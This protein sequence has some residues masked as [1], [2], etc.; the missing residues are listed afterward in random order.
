[1]NVTD[2]SDLKAQAQRRLPA[3]VYTYLEGGGYEEETLRRNRE[4]LRRF[5]LVPRVLH[6]VT[7]RNM[8]V[9]I[10]GQKLA[11]PLVL[12]PVGAC[13]LAYPNGEVEAAKAAKAHGIPFCL[14]TLSICTLED[15]A[16]AI[17]E[18]FWF[19][20]YV[21]RDRRVTEALVYRARDAGCSMLVMSLD[22]HVRSQRHEEQKHDLYAPPKIDFR[23]LWDALTHP[24]WLLPMLKSRRHTFGNLIGLVKDAR[25]VPEI[26]EWL[27]REFDP[28]VSLRDVE[29]ARKVWPGTLMVK[30]VLHPEDARQCIAHGADGVIVS[31]HGG[32]QV[33]GAVS[34]CAILPQVADAVN[35]AGAVLVDSGIRTGIDVLKMMARG[36]D[37]CLIGRAYMYGLAA[38]GRDGVSKA[39]D[40]ISK[41]LS[42]TM[43][44]CGC[45]DVRSLPFDLLVEEE[46]LL[47]ESA[48]IPEARARLI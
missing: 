15:V 25:S 40:I 36:A 44:L 24:R 16:E 48:R 32:R 45:T 6:D 29:W 20:L 3:V 43:G 27:E 1:M 39:I 2:I 13:G 12:G 18:P 9:Q 7:H 17:Q 4:D 28:T 10:A 30:G 11:L 22:L 37:A 35:G 33:D 41:E 34:T 42:Q 19:Q 46:S 23:N 8:A 5:A 21:T 26:T 47:R 31:N 14:S 38:N